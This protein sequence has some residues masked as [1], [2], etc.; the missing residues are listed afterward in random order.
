MKR[1]TPPKGNDISNIGLALETHTNHRSAYTGF[2]LFCRNCKLLFFS[3]TFT[4]RT[5]SNKE[6][7]LCSSKHSTGL[8]FFPFWKYWNLQSDHLEIFS[9]RAQRGHNS[10]HSGIILWSLCLLSATLERVLPAAAFVPSF[11]VASIP[12]RALITLY[13]NYLFIVCLSC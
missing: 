9:G 12:M 8:F 5:P 11:L 6:S 4:S 13:C 2:L 1:H 10:S 3:G 7:L